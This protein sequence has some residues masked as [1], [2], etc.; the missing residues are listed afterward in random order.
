AYTSLKS[1]PPTRWRRPNCWFSNF[2][3]K[4]SI[5][6][7]AFFYLFSNLKV[8]YI[9]VTQKLHIMSHE[10]KRT[11]TFNRPPQVVWEY[12]T[13]PELVGAWLAMTDIQ[14]VVGHQFSFLD[15]LGKAIHCEILEAEPFTRLSYSWR[16][17]SWAADR[18]F[19]STVAWT[20]LPTPDGTSLTLEH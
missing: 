1:P 8:T 3:S 6:R 19:D 11:W 7:A 13:K 16:F 5:S 12:L 17:P 14:P 20:L 15:K 9:W 2:P 18:H 10:I 4:P